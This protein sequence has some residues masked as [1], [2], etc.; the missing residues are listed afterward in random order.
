MILSVFS[1]S[2]LL[3]GRKN[4]NFFKIAVVGSGSMKRQYGAL[5]L[6]YTRFK[7]HSFLSEVGLADTYS[8]LS[9]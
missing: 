2:G 8:L 4:S 5:P 7:V 6:K 1:V 3:N 9:L